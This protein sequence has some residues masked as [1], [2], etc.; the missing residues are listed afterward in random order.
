[1]TTEEQERQAQQILTEICFTQLPRLG[2]FIS[3]KH[4]ANKF[5]DIAYEAMLNASRLIGDNK[6]E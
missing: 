6:N 5:I 3:E 4:K 2:N 1:M